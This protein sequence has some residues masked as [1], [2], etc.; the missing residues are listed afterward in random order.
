[1]KTPPLKRGDRIFVCRK[2]RTDIQPP[3]YPQQKSAGAAK[4]P[5]P[6]KEGAYPIWRIDAVSHLP[7]VLSVLDNQLEVVTSW[8]RAAR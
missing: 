1:M 4:A 5:N 6:L 7:V 2:G 8:I 3:H